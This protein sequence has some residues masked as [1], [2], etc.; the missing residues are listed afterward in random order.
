MSAPHRE[1][2]PSPDVRL[3]IAD[4]DPNLRSR[5]GAFFEQNGYAV[6]QV[7]DSE[8][9]LEEITALPSYDVVLLSVRLP[10]KG[11]FEVLREA[12]RAGADAPVILL[13]STGAL[14]D[15]LRG[16]ELGADDYVVKPFD[17]EELAARVRAVLR[18]SRSS[19][20]AGATQYAFGD[21]RVDLGKRLAHRGTELIEF[22]ELEFELLKHFI[23]HRGRTVSRKQLLR[24][25][26][27]VSG[28]I[29][30]RTIDRHVASLRQKIEPDSTD[31]TY[32]KTVY[33]VGYKFVG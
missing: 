22:T 19:S 29:T 7:A 11:G 5:L 25:I 4:P 12:R 16:F 2:A 26:W 3:L 1:K 18:R 24:N 32:I 14:A 10:G 27:G 8:A 33:G 23:A 17:I 20:E 30:T 28:E 6:S 15:T 9:A 21:V 31:P 13:A